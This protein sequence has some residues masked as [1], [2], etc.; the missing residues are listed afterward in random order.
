M[1]YHTAIS[2]A[3]LIVAW[4]L[5]SPSWS[6]L[7]EQQ[8]LLIG[9]TVVLV[10]LPIVA[11]GTFANFTVAQGELIALV[12]LGIKTGGYWALAHY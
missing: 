4:G 8:Q 6:G 12:V 2:V 7:E 1:T 3:V 11:P 10:L 5:N 9:A